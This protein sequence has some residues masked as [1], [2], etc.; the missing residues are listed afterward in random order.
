MPV[1]SGRINF[2]P[3]SKTLNFCFSKIPMKYSKNGQKFAMSKITSNTS[4]NTCWTPCKKP[5]FSTW[6]RSRYTFFWTTR[7]Q[8]RSGASALEPAPKSSLNWRRFMF[9]M[10]VCHNSVDISH[11]SEIQHMCDRQTNGRTDGRTKGRPMDRPYNAPSHRMQKH[12][13]KKLLFMPLSISVSFAWQKNS[14]C[15]SLFPKRRINPKT[16]MVV[17]WLLERSKWIIGVLVPVAA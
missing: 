5:H 6:S 7:Y 3:I 13:W 2:V 15:H 10:V 14:H 4:F 17:S 8:M 9:V 12:I 1:L 16:L 11:F